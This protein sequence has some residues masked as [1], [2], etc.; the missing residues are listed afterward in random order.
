MHFL[1]RTTLLVLLA[2]LPA[3]AE[4]AWTLLKPKAGISLSYRY[5]PNL[6]VK[7][8]A[9]YQGKPQSFLL[10][11]KDT[12]SVRSWLQ[13]SDDAKL[14]DGT[15]DHHWRVYTRFKSIWPVSPRDMVTCADWQ[16][17]ANQSLQIKITDCSNLLPEVKTHVRIRDVKA[18]WTITPRD[19][20][21][22][23]VYQGSANPGGGLPD[24]LV[25]QIT[26]NALRAS[27]V[28]FNT[29]LKRPAYQSD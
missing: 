28:A 9:F 13:Q 16:Q 12:A 6:E 27:F 8:S 18:L 1:V 2:C 14:L 11:L 17:L 5:N 20:G 7:A 26:L 15:T 10:L 25:K 23:L 24:W 21:F 4:P 19:Q 22:E 3:R 29:E